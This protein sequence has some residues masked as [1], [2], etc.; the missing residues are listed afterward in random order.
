MMQLISEPLNHILYIHRWKIV[1]NRNFYLI[2][3]L[4]VIGFILYFLWL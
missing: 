3:F 2:N 4:R 1:E